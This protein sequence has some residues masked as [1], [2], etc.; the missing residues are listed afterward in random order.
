VPWGRKEIGSSR[1]SFLAASKLKPDSKENVDELASALIVNQDYEPAWPPSIGSRCWA[2]DTRGDHY[3]ARHHARQNCISVRKRS[4]LIGLSSPA[5][6]D[7][8]G[9]GVSGPARARILEQ[10]INKR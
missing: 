8:P 2:G 9:P 7:D 3:L 6:M 10:E 1:Q 5:V 4:R